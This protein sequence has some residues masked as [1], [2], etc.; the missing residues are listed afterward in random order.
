MIG[1][2]LVA[3]GSISMIAHRIAVRLGQSEQAPQDQ[4]VIRVA[5]ALLVHTTIQGAV[6]HCAR[7]EMTTFLFSYWAIPF[8]VADFK[9]SLLLLLINTVVSGRVEKL[10]SAA[11]HK[12]TYF[13]ALDA[14]VLSEAERLCL[15]PDLTHLAD[16]TITGWETT[17]QT[18]AIAGPSDDLTAMRKILY[19]LFCM[20]LRC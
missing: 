2:S 18:M 7:A 20:G 17:V 3:L 12:T 4:R 11:M 10:F 6:Y 13:K 16:E 8:F 15:K 19:D 1:L 5:N 9:I 14:Q